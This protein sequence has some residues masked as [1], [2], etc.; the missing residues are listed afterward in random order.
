MVVAGDG[1]LGYYTASYSPA[2]G[3]LQWERS[4]QASARI[5]EYLSAL[6]VG[7]GGMIAVTGASNGDF[8]S[9]NRVLDYATVVYRE[10]LAPVS[11]ERLDAGVRLRF[12]GIAGRSYALERATSLRGRWNRIHTAIAPASGIV[13]HLENIP[14]TDNAFYRATEL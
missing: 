1:P 2:S 5:E 13:E 12:P 7:P 3:A 11:I 10:G 14:P 8:V 6:A 9:F 4:Y